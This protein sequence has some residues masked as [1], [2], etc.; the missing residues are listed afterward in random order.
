LHISSLFSFPY[1]FSD[2][3]Y[4]N[5]LAGD[6]EQNDTLVKCHQLARYF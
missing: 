5:K 4:E 2:E 3:G 1:D 6:E